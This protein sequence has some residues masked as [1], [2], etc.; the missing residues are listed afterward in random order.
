MSN[1]ATLTSSLTGEIRVVRVKG[2]RLSK[3]EQKSYFYTK[4]INLISSIQ[5]VLLHKLLHFFYTLNVAVFL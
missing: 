3:N 4:S 2:K 1:V 5:D